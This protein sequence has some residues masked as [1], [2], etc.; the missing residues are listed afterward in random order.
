[1]NVISTCTFACVAACIYKYKHSK[2]GA[3][4]GLV[5]GTVC[6]TLSMTLWN[7][8]ITPIYYQM[9]RSAVVGMLLPGIVPFN[10]IKC[11]LNAA[12]AMLI[13][14]PLVNALRNTQFVPQSST[15]E[16]LTKDVGIV[17]AF[18]IVSIAVLILVMK[19]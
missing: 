17:S 1:M 5:L 6:C 18:I 3:I 15:S 10:I 9:P 11:T 19:G 16:G 4:I 13:Y 12:C 14:K 8:I 7:Y 2:K